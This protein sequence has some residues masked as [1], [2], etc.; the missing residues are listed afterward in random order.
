LCCIADGADVENWVAR[1]GVRARIADAF[2]LPDVV[3]S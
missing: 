1:K 2:Q 3:A